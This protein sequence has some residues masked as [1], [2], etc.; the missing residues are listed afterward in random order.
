MLSIFAHRE[1]HS[2]AYV[3]QFFSGLVIS[4][5]QS[6]GFRKHKTVAEVL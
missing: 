4:E 1:V 2:L 6:I 5:K 3:A